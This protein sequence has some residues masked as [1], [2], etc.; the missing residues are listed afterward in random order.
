MQGATIKKMQVL[1]SLHL[2]K[3]LQKNQ[4]KVPL[5]RQMNKVH[6]SNNPTMFRLKII[7]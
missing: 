5:L 2:L 6:N 4:T 7:L 3:F 1:N